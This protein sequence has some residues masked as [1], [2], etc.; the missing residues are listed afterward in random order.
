MLCSRC[1][2]TIKPIVALDID[3]VLGD[4]HGHFLRFATGYFGYDTEKLLQMSLDRYKGDQKF[5]TYCTHHFGVTHAEYRECKL[6]Y[7]QGGMKRSQPINEGAIRLCSV[8]RKNAELWI[9]TTRPFLSLDGIIKDTMFWLNLHDIQYDGLLYDDDKYVT[10]AERVDPARVAA[11]LD[12]LDVMYDAAEQIYGE[13]VPLLYLNG[14]NSAMGWDRNTVESLDQARG[15]IDLRI[16]SW[17][18]TNA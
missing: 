4:Y 13:N 7:R 9:T 11:I 1:S 15:L 17:V 10:L 3:G 2:E 18:Y 6:A 8:I 12:D 5:S 14:F 16:E